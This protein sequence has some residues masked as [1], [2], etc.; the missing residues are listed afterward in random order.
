MLLCPTVKRGQFQRIVIIAILLGT[1]L[2]ASAK[3][4]PKPK[5]K[6]NAQFVSQSVPT[7]MVT[8]QNYSVSVT[9]FNSGTKAWSPTT[10]ALSSQNPAGN[11]TWGLTSSGLLNSV[12]SGVTQ[13]FNFTV[14][15]PSTPGTYNFQWRLTNASTPFGQLTQNVPIAVAT[16]TPSPSPSPSPSATPSPTPGGNAPTVFIAH[17]R[18]Q[19]DGSTGV[20]TAV[21]KLA[22]DELSATVAFNFS[23]LSTPVTA[24]HVHGPADAGQSAGIL[25]D[26]DTTPVRP[27]GTYLWVFAPVGTNSVA[28]IVAAIKSGRTYFNI[29]TTNNPKGEILGFLNLAGGNES[30]PVPTPPPPLPNGTPTAQDAARFLN[31]CTCGATESTV[32]HVQQVGFSNFLDEQFAIPASSNLQWVDSHSSDPGWSDTMQGWWTLAISAPD[33]VR[34]RVAFALSEILVTSFNDGDLS[35]NGVAMSAYIDILSNGAFGNYRQLLQNVTLSP[36]MGVYLDMLG[37]DKADPDSGSHP[38]EN[39]AR[40]LMQLFSIGL[41][42]LNIDGSLALD[43]NALP[44]PTYDQSAV[45]GL[46]AVTTGWTFAGQSDFWNWNPNYRQ[47]MQAFPEHHE[48]GTKQIL[49]G[50]VIPANQG[51]S[52]DLNLA[53]N[54]IFNHPNVGRFVGRQLIQRMVTSNPSPGYL[55]RVAGAFDNNG[56]GVRG[57]MKAVIKAILLDYDARG[58]GK[59]GQGAGKLR[60]PVLRLTHLYRALHGQPSDG[61]FSFWIPDEFGEQPLNSP[62]VFNFFTPD[63][64]APGA[65]ALAGLFSPELKITTEKTVVAQANQVYEALFWEDI[66]LD[67][68]TE[69]T[70]S[71]DAAALVDLLNVKLMN[72]AMSSAMRQTLIDTINQM[73]VDDDWERARAAVW[74][75]LNSPEYVVEK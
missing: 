48:P 63:Y 53:L 24:K 25:F 57:D 47:Q 20:G 64:V 35:D 2:S 37:N 39:Y 14:N 41:F 10:V 11:S 60:E 50:V 36:T 7:T 34:Q 69:E 62:T 29:H 15:A 71:N 32:Q 75:V 40:E 49:N 33:Q 31:Q 17:L 21:L 13:T 28:D 9:M 19:S 55:Y 16:P 8:G 70:L 68:S 1:A 12:A 5:T 26:L 45:E 54:T 59:T 4:K 52:Q 27:D 58:P 46:A 43:G 22:A 74:L 65:I 61:I 66:P 44:I 6:L 51:P 67:L 3:K 23:N 72:G 30:V 73:P 42:Q 38:N 56:Q 18:A